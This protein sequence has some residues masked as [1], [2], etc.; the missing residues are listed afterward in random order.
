[1][2]ERAD[3]D[4]TI[5]EQLWVLSPLSTLPSNKV[6]IVLHLRSAFTASLSSSVMGYPVEHGRRYHAYQKGCTWRT[7]FLDDVGISAC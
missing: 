2:Q 4:A 6:L 1:M 7:L 5:D 3:D